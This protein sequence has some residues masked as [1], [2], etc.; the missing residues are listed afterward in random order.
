VAGRRAE[1][2]K[3]QDRLSG[4]AE[5]RRTDRAAVR[6]REKPPIAADGK[7]HFDQPRSRLIRA[8]APV[9]RRLTVGSGAFLIRSLSP[10]SIRHMV[11]AAY[12]T[13]SNPPRSF[14]VRVGRRVPLPLLANKLSVCGVAIEIEG[15]PR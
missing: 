14:V 12:A 8:L 15:A 3:G 2:P 1:A 11:D 7:P 13:A 10:S 5:Q 4:E 9:S 6:G